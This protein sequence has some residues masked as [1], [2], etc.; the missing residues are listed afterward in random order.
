[1]GAKSN[2]MLKHSGS[3]TRQGEDG[4][5]ERVFFTQAQ[6]KISGLTNAKRYR[7]VR[8]KKICFY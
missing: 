4:A 7:S 1:M 8:Y 2:T 5:D 6:R 3:T